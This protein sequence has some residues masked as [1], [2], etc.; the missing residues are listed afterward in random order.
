ME[1]I[2][3]MARAVAITPSVFSFCPA[4]TVCETNIVTPLLVPIAIADKI[5]TTAVEF[6]NAA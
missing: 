3:D 5:K 6:V 4:P 2:A 1:K